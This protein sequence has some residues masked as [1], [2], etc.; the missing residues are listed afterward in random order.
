MRENNEKQMRNECTVTAIEVLHSLKTSGKVY[1]TFCV[2]TYLGYGVFK[3]K[4][5]F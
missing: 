5:W 1:L 2:Y 4:S 3:V